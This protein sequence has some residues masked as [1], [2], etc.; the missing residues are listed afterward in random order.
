[1]FQKKK[2]AQQIPLSSLSRGES[3]ENIDEWPWLA[4]IGSHKGSPM[5]AVIGLHISELGGEVAISYVE[6]NFVP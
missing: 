4:K 3:R 2:L 1:M 6:H 5:A